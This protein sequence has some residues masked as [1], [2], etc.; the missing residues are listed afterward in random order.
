[1]NAPPSGGDDDQAR[2]DRELREALLDLAYDASSYLR[3]HA[4]ATVRVSAALL[5]AAS[6]A[7]CGPSATPVPGL[8]VVQP[9]QSEV[10]TGLPATPGRYPVILSTLG[11]D[12][13]GVYHFAWQSPNV[14]NS[15]N[16]ASV[17]RLRLAEANPPV[18]EMP[19]SGDPI[20]YL[21][22]DVSIP[23]MDRYVPGTTYS[24][25][26]SSYYYWRPFYGSSYRGTGYYDPPD[27][28]APSCG[29]TLD[30]ARVSSSP[31]PLGARTVG[32]RGAVAAK[33]G[34]AGSG[35][36]ATNKSGASVSSTGHGGAAA[37]K[38][39][40]FSSGHAGSSGGSSSS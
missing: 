3:R 31:A 26:G 11:R 6:L 14:P 20:L 30:G 13:Q 12:S 8:G 18:L 36:A 24:S 1:L 4:K 7:A 32:V 17:S 28:T 9:L 10:R 21:P 34:G 35:T 16:Y 29:S 5:V 19:P 39:G 27:K 37:A 15:R 22:P 40:G 23:L 2:R 38:S 33:A 25:G